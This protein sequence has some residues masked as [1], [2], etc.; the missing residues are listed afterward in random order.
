MKYKFIDPNG[1]IGI[2][3]GIYPAIINAFKSRKLAEKLPPFRVEW[4][5]ERTGH[6]VLVS[7]IDGVELGYVEKIVNG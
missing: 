6:G 3:Q 1:K 4:C 5:N 2:A 7:K